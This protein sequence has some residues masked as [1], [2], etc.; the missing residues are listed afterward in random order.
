MGIEMENTLGSIKQSQ[1][2][3]FMVLNNDSN[4]GNVWRGQLSGEV[5]EEIN[6]ESQQE[7]VSGF[8]SKVY[9]IEVKEYMNYDLGGVWYGDT[10]KGN[11]SNF[12]ISSEGK[13]YL[14][15]RRVAERRPRAEQALSW[16]KLSSLEL[17]AE[18][19]RWRTTSRS[20]RARHLLK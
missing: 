12:N 13:K 19:I 10:G 9:D 4:D 1:I 3:S 7:E 15:K 20:R 2:A 11:N 6:K 16:S 5:D 17:A 8:Y 14:L 18:N